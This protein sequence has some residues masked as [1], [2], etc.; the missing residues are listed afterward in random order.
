MVKR[1]LRGFPTPASPSGAEQVASSV[2]LPVKVSSR[3]SGFAVFLLIVQPDT[4]ARWHR[5]GS[6]LY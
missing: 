3:G 2:K 1:R 6:K 4:V 5:Q